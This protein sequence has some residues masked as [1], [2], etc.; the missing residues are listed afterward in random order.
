[1]N[2]RFWF[3]A[4]AIFLLA[5]IFMSACSPSAP[6]TPDPNAAKPSNPGGTGKALTL[7]GDAA[8]GK[9]VF[10]SNCASC[11]GTDGKGGVPNEGSE[12]GTVPALNP[13][14]ETIANKDPK[15]FAANLD[16]FIEHGST[17]AGDS[18]SRI[19]LAFGDSQ[20]LQPQQIADVIAYV[21]SLN[22]K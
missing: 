5:A 22:Q 11:H 1:M 14:D 4:A 21:I 13:V 20:I 16:L 7:K 19:M 12:D 9:A 10:D 8:N 3:R 15:V 6:A 18:P 2:S 17:P